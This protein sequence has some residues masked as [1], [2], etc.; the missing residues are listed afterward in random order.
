MIDTFTAILNKHEADDDAQISETEL[1]ESAVRKEFANGKELL[2]AY[3]ASFIT[4][5]DFISGKVTNL[6]V[7]PIRQSD[8]FYIKK[9][10][11]SQYPYFHSHNFY[12]LIYVRKG[13][14]LQKFDNG[15]Q[16]NLI[17]KQCLLIPPNT[18]HSIEKCG[19][20]DVILKMVIPCKIFEQTGGAVIG[21]CFSGAYKIFNSVTSTAEFIILKLLEEQYG[22]NKFKNLILQSYLTILFAELV[23]Y[24]QND[25]ALET[26]LNNY[27]D[28]SFR[29][30][31]LLEFATLL[32]Y[33]ANYV[34]RLIKKRTGKSFSDLLTR[35][36]INRAKDLLIESAMTIEEIAFNVGYSTASGLYKQF[37]TQLGVSP[38][39][40]RNLFK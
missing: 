34:S 30:A 16:L 2:I 4:L 15:S 36:R 21:G 23:G 29:T 12:E 32:N 35:Y 40:Y 5:H 39:E 24:Q 22:K 11:Q 14:C 31:S 28:E 37:F 13:K 19:H 27:F 18:I 20:S 26:L 3:K 9:H 38:A 6:P 33:N 8:E 7:I 1:F 25:V 17:E 10:T